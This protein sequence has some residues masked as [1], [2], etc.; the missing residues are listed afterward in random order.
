MLATHVGT[1]GQKKGDGER[2]QVMQMQ[3]E[4]ERATQVELQ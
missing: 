2:A 3:I 4:Q 1:V